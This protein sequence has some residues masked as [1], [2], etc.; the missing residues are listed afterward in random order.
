[1]EQ[2]KTYFNSVI[3]ESEFELLSPLLIEKTIDEQNKIPKS[4]RYPYA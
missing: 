1:M 4:I 2:L 3:S